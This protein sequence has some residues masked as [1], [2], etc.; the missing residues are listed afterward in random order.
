MKP[1]FSR[2]L[3]KSE[4]WTLFLVFTPVTLILVAMVFVVIATWTDPQAGLK[5]NEVPVKQ[6][7]L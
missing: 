6:L 1:I 4:K 3:T 7:D 2:K 5:Q